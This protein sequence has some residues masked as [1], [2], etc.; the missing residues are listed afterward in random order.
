ML[1]PMTLWTRINLCMVTEYQNYFHYGPYQELNLTIFAVC[2]MSV[3]IH[4][5]DVGGTCWH[6]DICA[7]QEKKIIWSKKTSA[8]KGYMYFAHIF[9]LI[10]G[11]CVM[12][13]YSP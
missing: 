13:L 7:Q 2:N 8:T 4:S 12:A 11:I 9:V 3:H 5:K 1:V 6:Y 10:I